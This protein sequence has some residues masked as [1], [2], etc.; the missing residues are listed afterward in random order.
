VQGEILEGL[1]P[2]IVPRQSSVQMEEVFKN[3]HQAPLDGGKELELKLFAL[4]S[5]FF[6]YKIIFV[7]V[8]T[9]C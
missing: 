9:I 1:V 4:L 7:C 3:F 8:F 5:L 2:R 6:Q